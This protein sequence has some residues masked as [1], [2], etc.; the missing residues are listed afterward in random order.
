MT[1][2]QK[3]G[4][5]LN[6]GRLALR[7]VVVVLAVFIFVSGLAVAQEE[8]PVSESP[9]DGPVIPEVV[10]EGVIP[11]AD[12]PDLI[13]ETDS[14]RYQ[15]KGGLFDGGRRTN[16]SL[17]ES[18]SLRSIIDLRELTERAPID[19]FQ[20]LEREVGVLVQRT[21]RGAAAPFVRGLTGQQ[22]LILV[23]GIRMNNATFRL[24]PNQYFNTIDP[25]MVDHIEVIRGPQTVLYGSD[26]FGGVINVV[27]RRTAEGGTPDGPL[28]TWY[29][30]YSSADNGFYSRMNWQHYTGDTGIF[31]GAGYANV[32]SLDRGGD[33]GRQPWTDFAQYS[34]DI[35]IDRKIAENQM[36]T[37]SFQQFVQEDVAR[38]DRFPNRLTVF[39]P[40]QRTMA[41]VRLQGAKMGTFF[42]TYSLTFSY[43]RQREGSTDRRFSK[44]YYDVMETDNQ[45]LGMTLVMNT[46]LS[47]KDQLVYGAD[48]YYD[49][50][51]AFRDRYEFGTNSYLSSPTP[52][53][54]D[55][56]L[57]RQT[58]AFVQWDHEI[59]DRLSSTAGVRYTR[60]GAKATPVIDVDDDNDPNT[61][62]VPT[63]VYI[64]PTFGDWTAS[65]GL[66]Y[67]LDEDTV[68][69]GSFSEGFRAPNLD[70]LAATNDNVQ[71]AAADTPSVD[72]QPERNQ[73]F[74]IGLRKETD[75]IRWQASYF[76][77][78]IDDMILRTPAGDDGDSILFSR[79][80]RDANINGFE[81]AGEKRIDDHWTMYGNFAYYLGVDRELDMPLS[82]I[83]PT[84]GILGLRWRS[85]E[86]YEYLD[87]YTWMAKRQDRLNFQDI[88]D[89]RIPDGGT[90]GYATFNLRYGTM[91]SETRH[92]TIELEN[93]LDKDYR[94][95]GSGVDG[96]GFSL[97]V[98]YAVEF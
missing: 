47:E 49:D 56:G 55:D 41:Y 58:G 3:P 78:D 36:I 8:E 21:Q 38:S 39:D 14:R 82:R 73:S 44:N 91:L 10:V 19:M 98:Q 12:S 29:N 83:P 1:V 88:S 61:D 63:N 96:A 48:L 40:Q 24:G 25:G 85:T 71:Q 69:V 77:M 34:G 2:I 4:Q 52:K 53:Y 20:A 90:P 28:K 94:V 35:R 23:D 86:K 18:P 51:D 72:L 50:V 57:Y 54:P 6:R 30:R 59:N 37:Y 31:A 93:I 27:T 11:F 75:T 16:L 67:E 81:F 43:Q 42:D 5:V 76:W 26:A 92:L 17:F 22:V 32:N 80:N 70:D 65:A 66:T 62:P 9:S 45:S 84:Q 64:D 74:E 97:N 89:N 46:K 87:F 95:H 79:S 60:V 13:W 15:G 33:L 68:L 7:A